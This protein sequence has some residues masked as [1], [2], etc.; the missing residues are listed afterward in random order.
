M[1]NLTRGGFR[2][3]G[4]FDAVSQK[5]P[6]IEV[7]PVASAYGT[8]IRRGDPVKLLSTGYMDIAAPGETPYGVCDGVTQYYDGVAIRSGQALPAST[9]YSTNFSRQSLIRVIPVR[10]QKFEIDADLT[11]GA[12]TWA[13]WL[14][15][16]GENADW[17]AGTASGDMSGVVLDISTHNTTNSLG[18]RIREVVSPNLQELDAARVKLM[19]EFNLVQSTTAGST[20]GT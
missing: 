5:E 16:I 18:C 9:T 8:A 11:D 14:A 1:A 4:S 15:L 6:P 12:T 17:V 13:G 3:R 2:W 20:T 7:L 19:I 10:G